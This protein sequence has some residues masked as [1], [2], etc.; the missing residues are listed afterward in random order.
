MYDP[1]PTTI[2]SRSTAEKIHSRVEEMNIEL[3]D[4]SSVIRITASFGMAAYDIEPRENT[5]PLIKRA[6]DALYRAKREGRNR[7]C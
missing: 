7:V 2:D 1:R 4:G 3:A 5:D 6:D